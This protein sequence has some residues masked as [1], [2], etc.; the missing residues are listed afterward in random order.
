MNLPIVSNLR[1]KTPLKKIVLAAVTAVMITVL[2]LL[3]ISV[4]H[5]RMISPEPTLL[6]EDRYHN[7]IASFENERD[8]FGFWPLPD[9]LP[10]KITAMTI[11]AEDWRFHTHRGV[12]LRAVAR[13]IHTNYITKKSYS[14]AS[15]LAMQVVRMQYDS[16]RRSL[17]RK[18]HESLTALWITA[19]YGREQVMRQ[20]L[21]IAPYGNRIAGVNYAARRYYQKPLVDLSWAESALLAALPNAPGRMNLY[22]YHGFSRASARARTILKKAK[23]L[24]FIS[25]TEYN[26]AVRELADLKIPEKEKRP[27]N[28]IH[29]MMAARN[30]IEKNPG[31]IDMDPLNPTVRLTLDSD[32]H[33][34]VHTVL[35]DHFRRNLRFE[36]D[37]CAA[38][39]IDRKSGDLLSYHG[40][41]SYSDS[42]H[43]G[44]IDFADAKR[45]TGS[46]LKPFIYGC[47]IEWN[48]YTPATL[49]TDIGLYFGEGNRA[50]T[51]QN[52]DKKYLGPVL[53]KTALANSRNVPAV[54]VLKDIG[55]DLFYQRLSQ[56]GV[57]PDD[58]KHDYY[59]LGIAVGNLYASLYT[60]TEAYLSLA[61][62]GEKRE[63]LWL[64]D[65]EKEKGRAVLER[66]A[67]L[68]VQRMLSDPLA[69]LPSFPR[70]GFLEYPYPVA[71][72]TGT[73]RGYRDAWCI[74]WSDTY[75]VGVW[76]GKANNRPMKG[77]SGYGGA[78]P[79]VK[80]I[81]KKL[82]RDRTGGLENIS[83]PPP[84]GYTPVMIN[85]LTGERAAENSPWATMEYF[86]PGTEPTGESDP[87]R[88][89]SL[90]ERS[91]KLATPACDRAHVTAKRY[92]HFP[93]IFKDWAHAQGIPA[94]P[95][96]Y[97]T[98]CGG[99]ATAVEEY[100]LNITYPIRNSTL[101]IDP[102][103]PA[104][105]SAVTLNCAVKPKSKSVLWEVDGKEYKLVD[106]PYSTSW[107]LTPGSH[108]FRVKIPRTPFVSSPVSIEVY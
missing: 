54:Q 89:V 51:P 1:R 108:T 42:R 10:E 41:E 57:V 66:D 11:A 96:E 67:A 98:L 62:E 104:E 22:R 53:Y 74:A 15:T 5:I 73:S 92:L 35:K 43:F 93:T 59:G 40:S 61:N 12:D 81:M 50:F 103:M 105:Y 83:F 97:C 8:Q 37:N 30:Y 25:E 107:N 85:I 9:T 36:I 28:M 80:D 34:T 79:F 2:T 86:R 82:H 102:E 75:V 70:G 99:S 6:L 13:A 26:Q 31:K 78:A 18:V 87:F 38:L 21:T 46:L 24:G 47:G 101:Y 56:F 17:F 69:R 32:I 88:W 7:F 45:S 44:Q 4:S 64:Y 23:H 29:A 106:Y 77:V 55:A 100:A 16:S 20:Y 72:K 14:G 65:D 91:G 76:L 48:S 27:L 60:L 49:L 95:G 68:Q 90:D 94:P 33:D 84:P 63:I 52:Y 19:I 39:V 71:V 3:I 58:S